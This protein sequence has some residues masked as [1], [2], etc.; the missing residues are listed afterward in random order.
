MKIKGR[1][2]IARKCEIMADKMTKKDYLTQIK[3]NYALTEDEV[4]F[5][6]HE[7]ELLTKRSAG[8][9]KPS[10]RQTENEA[11]KQ[12]ILDE[13][14]ENTLYTIEEMT[15]TLDCLSGLSSQRVSALVSQLVKELKVVRTVDKRK[16]YFS[17]A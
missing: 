15:K 3:E 4:A 7:I 2:Q 11:L 12:S 13:M 10:A 17:L 5:I 8:E 16:A 1:N 9:R 6:D 14:V